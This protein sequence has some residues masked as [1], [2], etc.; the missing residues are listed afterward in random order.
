[1]KSFKPHLEILPPAQK[2]LWEELDET[3]EIFTLYGGTALALRLGH[4]RSVD[5]DF[6]SNAPFDPETLY[7]T[8][9]YLKGAEIVE[10]SRQTLTCRVERGGPIKVQFFGALSL[11]SLEEPEKPEDRKIKVAGFKDIG[12]TKVKVLPERAEE[13]DYIDV[14]ALLEHGEKLEMLLGAA[15]A[16]YGEVF[17]P[18]LAVKALTYFGDVPRLPQKTQERIRQAAL[19]V[20]LT[21]L[22]K[23]T[24][25]RAVSPRTL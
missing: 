7:K 10:T 16:V 1:M 20:D 3:P 8:I 2:K 25:Q 11:G 21:H 19:G 9:T 23:L 5:F 17:N 6:F 13:K 12:A 18:V 22:P 15:Q 14:A 4:R 24:P